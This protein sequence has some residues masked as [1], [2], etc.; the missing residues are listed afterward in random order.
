MKPN[1]FKYSVLTVGVIAAMGIAGT[2]NADTITYTEGDAFS[3]KNVASATYNVAGNNTQQTAESNEVTITVSELGQFTL[4]ATGGASATDDVNENIAVNPVSGAP[5]DFTHILSNDGN[6]TDTYTIDISNEGGDDFDYD[7][8]NSTITYQKRDADGNLF[9]NVETIANGGS[10]QLNPGESADITITAVT[11]PNDDRVI[12]DNGILTVTSTSKYLNDKGQTA[13]ATNTD[14]AITTTPIYAITKSARTNLGTKIIDLNNPNAYV[15]YTITVLNEGTADGTDVTITDALPDGLIAIQNGEAN[16][17]APTTTGS[18]NNVTPVISADGRTV[19]VTG[20]DIDQNDTIT[21]TFRARAADNA[22]QASTFNNYA[23]VTDDLD[24]DGDV[25]LTDSSGD[26]TDPNTNENNFEDPA[27]P[28]VGQDN[29]DDATVTPKNQ[30]RDLNITPAAD[31]EVALQSTNNGYTYTISNDGTDVIEA[32]APNEVLFTVTPTTDI[33]EIDITTVFVDTNGDGV[34]NNGETVLTPNAQGQYD[35]NDA[36]PNGLAAGESVNI[37]VLVDTSGSGS[38]NG[39]DSDIGKSEEFTITVLPQTVVDGTPA[40]TDDI[41]ES[42]TTTMQGIDLFKYQAAAVCGTNPTSITDWVTTN[43]TATAD[44]CAFYRLEATNTFSNTAIT[45][46]VLSDTLVDTLTYQ[47]DFSS[48]TSNNSDP[49]SSNI[50]G[51]NIVGTFD[52]L[53]GTETGTIY[54]S[55][56]ISQTGTNST[57]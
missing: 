8:A 36:A 47:G 45:N 26:N 10:I 1:A 18:A 40:P 29:N 11:D 39:Q 32:D 19:T 6:V 50:S 42:S 28:D 16:Y 5:V 22:T 27:N 13:T 2:A 31:K 34:L 15:D 25:D 3:V 7:I 20:Q 24:D 35:L 51:Q 37:G 55:A 56:K 38:N 30:N 48:V 54:F 23:V 17:V 43:V 44:Q 52:T 14:N 57:P 41:S 49:A 46:V 12:G 4:V 21:I 33:N 9:G 53:T